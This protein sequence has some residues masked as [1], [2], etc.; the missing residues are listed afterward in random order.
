MGIGDGSGDKSV[1]VGVDGSEGSRRA[2]EWTLN[3]ADRFGE[4]RTLTAYRVGPFG[5][6]FGGYVGGPSSLE[7]Y[8][9]AAEQRLRDVLNATDPALIASALI[10]ESRA[11][12]ALVDAARHASLLVVGNKGRGALIE[13]LLGSVGS[14][15]VKHASVPVAVIAGDVPSDRKIR[16]ALVAVDGSENSLAALRWAFDHVEPEAALT[17]LGVYNPVASS[18]EGYV[19]PLDLLEKQ[20]LS[21]VEDSIADLLSSSRQPGDPQASVGPSIEIEIQAG[22]PRAVIRELARSCDLLV[23]GARGHRGIGH[24]LLGSVTSSL[25]HHPTVPT[26]VV[27]H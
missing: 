9:D 8:R 25:I 23:L 3:K 10:V 2:L 24:L 14:Y 16:K 6:G 17:V 19:P 22:D 21:V 5:D 7:I 4:V 18:F 26:V 1:L 12:S 27:P 15:C 11:G 20:T 13:T